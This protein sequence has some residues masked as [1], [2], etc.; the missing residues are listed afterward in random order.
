[1]YMYRKSIHIHVYQKPKRK[2]LRLCTFVDYL[3]YSTSTVHVHVH[4]LV[5]VLVLVLVHVHYQA[6]DKCLKHVQ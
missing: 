6:L 4:V 5:H 2:L 1:M 3:Q